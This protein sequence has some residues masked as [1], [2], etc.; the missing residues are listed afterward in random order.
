MLPE[1]HEVL[2]AELFGHFK[3]AVPALKARVFFRKTDKVRLNITFY[4]A[5]SHRN[6][7][8]ENLSSA[9]NSNRWRNILIALVAVILS[10]ALFWGLKTE[11]SSTS[12]E[13]QAKN[14]VALDT[15]LNNGKPTLVEFYADWCTSCQA[16]SKDLGQLK[17]EYGQNLNFVMLNVDN[18]KWL[19]EMLQYR[20]DGIPHFV[21]IDA[22]GTEIAQTIGEQPLPVMAANLDALISDSPLPY[23]YSNGQISNFTAPITTSSANQDDPRS[24]GAQVN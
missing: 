9:P 23:T 1:I 13:N 20:V 11:T 6:H 8:S 12:L 24:H 7:M 4:F 10:F 21:F 15:A 5:N 18:T 14:S 17:Q 2:R 16:M 22:Q 19:P 3:S